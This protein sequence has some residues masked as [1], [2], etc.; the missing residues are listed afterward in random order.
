LLHFN[1]LML[2]ESS[3]ISEK[4]HLAAFD[5]WLS[6]AA[7]IALAL[8]AHSFV[9]VPARKLILR[10]FGRKEAVAKKEPA[11]GAYSELSYS[12]R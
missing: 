8:A 5:P 11:E 1:A 7:V 4:L 10:H 9:E 2:I 6:Y 3:H 12:R